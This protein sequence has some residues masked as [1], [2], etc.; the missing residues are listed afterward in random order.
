MWQD[1]DFD[2]KQLYIRRTIQRIKCEN[3]DTKT[4]VTLLS[5]KSKSSQRTIPLPEL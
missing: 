2:T 3:N 5:P 4:S 1:I